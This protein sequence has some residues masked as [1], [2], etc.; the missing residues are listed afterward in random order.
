[1]TTTVSSPAIVPTTSCS[2]DRSIALA[3][4]WAAPGALHAADRAAVLRDHVDR[5]SPVGATQLHRA[6][7]VEVPGQGRLG[8]V[9]PFPGKEFGQ[10]GLAADA[11]RGDQLDDPGLPGHAGGRGVGHD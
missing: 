8:D 5:D 9:D 4:N 7:L 11:H 6:E 1:M 2:A 3:R 10:L